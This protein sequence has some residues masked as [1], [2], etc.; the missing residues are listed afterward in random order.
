MMIGLCRGIASESENQKRPHQRLEPES[1][2]LLPA[3]LL[4]EVMLEAWLE[5]ELTWGT[6][7]ITSRS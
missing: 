2:P 4:A 7:R 6:F 3:N 5:E 1:Q